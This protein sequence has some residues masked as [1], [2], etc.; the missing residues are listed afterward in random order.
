MCACNSKYQFLSCLLRDHLYLWDGKTLL[1]EKVLH[2]CRLS[3]EIPIGMFSLSER[4]VLVGARSGGMYVLDAV[5]GE[6]LHTL[7]KVDGFFEIDCKFVSDE[8]CVISSRAASGGYCLQLFN[9]KSGDLL[10]VIELEERVYRLAACPR[11]RLL[12]IVQ[13]DSHQGFK[14]IQVHL[15]QDKDSRKIKR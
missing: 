14:L 15:P 13:G 7:C 12:A 4:F 10:S 6:T 1:W 2:L 9:V 11:K 5:S 3:F 8:E